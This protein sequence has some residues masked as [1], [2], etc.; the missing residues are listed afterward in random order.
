[1]SLET[2]LIFLVI[3]GLIGYIVQK[4]WDFNP[5]TYYE[6][7][8]AVSVVLS[9]IIA[10]LPVIF[11][12]EDVINNTNRIVN[13]FVAILPGTIIGDVAGQIIYKWTGE[14]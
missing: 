3:F 9:L 12:P 14:K 1:M 2:N 5:Y 8:G 13:W 6:R 11:N 4:V 7:F 10:Y